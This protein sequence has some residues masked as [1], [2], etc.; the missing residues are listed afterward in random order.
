MI[1][2]LLFLF[3]FFLRIDTFLNKDIS[4]IKFLF[5]FH[6]LIIADTIS[7]KLQPIFYLTKCQKHS[8]S[9]KS[10]GLTINKKKF[11]NFFFLSVSLSV[12][13][14]TSFFLLHGC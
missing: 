2:T 9:G 12:L 14:L 11:P 7:C 3:L 1:F 10:V 6:P 4:Y 5:I 13:R 8:Q